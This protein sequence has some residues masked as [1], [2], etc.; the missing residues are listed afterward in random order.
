M[1]IDQTKPYRQTIVVIPRRITATE[2]DLLAMATALAT[3]NTL[4]KRD[5]NGIAF[6]NRYE[7]IVYSG[8][9]TAVGN[10]AW[11][12]ISF[13]TQRSQIGSLWSSS[14]NPTRFTAPVAGIYRIGANITFPSNAT[15]D[16]AIAVRLNGS[17]FIGAQVSRAASGTDHHMNLNRPYL[18]AAGDYVE[19]MAFQTSGASQNIVVQNGLSPEAWILAE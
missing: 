7:A 1:P 10:G 6:I 18:L 8:V 12:P 17:T 2:Q 11:T 14:V 16:R 9:T 13:N 5:A 19:I 15:G 4:V 3:A